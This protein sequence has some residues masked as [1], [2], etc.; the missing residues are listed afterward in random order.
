MTANGYLQLGLYMAL[1]L[2]AAK[3]LGLYMAWVYEGSTWVQRKLAPLERWLY[4]LC[5]IDPDAEMNWR[6]YALA[7]IWFSVVSFV[8]L[9]LLQRLQGWLPLNPEQLGAVSPHSSFNT[10]V[11]FVTNTNWQGYGGETTM[12][13]LTQML[14]L[15]V[16]NFV[17]AAAGM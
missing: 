8:L 10:A 14:G 11:S 5:A 2:A 9:Y 7:V 6:Q 4:R 12:S 3:P 16:Q 17:S 15:S 1:L 13:Y